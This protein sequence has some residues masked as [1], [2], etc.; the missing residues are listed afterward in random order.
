MPA[1]SI[2]LA[3][4]RVTSAGGEHRSDDDHSVIGRNARPARSGE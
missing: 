4:T 1:T 3:P 2:G